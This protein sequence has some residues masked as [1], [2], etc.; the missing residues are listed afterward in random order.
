[1]QLKTQV[2]NILSEFPKTR[3]SDITLM[4]HLWNKYYPAHIKNTTGGQGIFLSSLYYL[5]TQEAI[6]RLRAVVQNDEHK[7]LPTDPKVRKQR[8][9]KEEEFR[10]YINSLTEYKR[11]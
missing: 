8:R 11:I 6:K 4:I 1:M 2:E 10:S 9:I 5:P 7:Y 3:D